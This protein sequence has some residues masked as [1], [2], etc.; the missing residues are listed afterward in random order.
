[1]SQLPSFN[2]L[3]LRAPL[4]SAITELGYETPTPVQ[5]QSIP[6][7]L[8]G[9]DLLA[10]AQTGTGKTAAFAL[11]ILSQI[12]LSVSAPQALI[13]TPTRE[14]AI[15]V[16]EAFQ[17]YARALKGFHVIPIY[18]GQSYTIQLNALK[19]GVQVIVGTPG[20]V[21]DHLRR[22]TIPVNAIKTVVLDEADEMLT[23]GFIEDITWILEQ[24]PHAHQTALFSATMPAAIQQVAKKY[25]ND[26]C[27]V[28]IKPNKQNVAAIEQC[29]IRISANQKL[30]LLTRLLEVETIQAAIVFARTK[31]GSSE[32]AEKLKARGYAATALNGD[33]NQAWREKVIDQLKRGAVDIVVAT[34]VAARGI[35]VERISHVFNFD[36]P[37]DVESYI[38]RIGR[39]G[40]AGRSGKAVLFVTPREY[41]LLNAIERGVQSPIEEIFPPTLKE[42]AEKRGEQLVA[43]V[44]GVLNT[45]DARN[46]TSAINAKGDSTNV[47]HANVHASAEARIFAVRPYLHY[48][49]MI[50]AKTGHDAKAI[51]AALAYL[52]QQDNPMPIDEL[53]RPARDYGRASRGASSKERRSYG[54]NP[55]GK[56]PIKSSKPHKS[57]KSGSSGKSNK[58]SSGNS[59]LSK[60]NY[61]FSKEG[62]TNEKSRMN[63]KSRINE[64]NGPNEKSKSKGKRSKKI[65]QNA[66]QTKPAKPAKLEK[67]TRSTKSAKPKKTVGSSSS[68]SLPD[69]GSPSSLRGG[70]AQRRSTKQSTL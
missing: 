11:P 43:Q 57:K 53:E 16:A 48:I 32:L 60:S 5:A 29:Y 27:H 61:S 3:N 51:A 10:Q 58:L 36:I 31:N 4:L 64:K 62:R 34:D 26:A 8:E 66:G 44:M 39:T 38:H 47:P 50:M 41:R 21:M 17:R 6:V 69:S 20:R 13:I 40:R 65:I 46:A 67:P 19:R 70:Q 55:Y 14:L 68:S 28:Q 37:Y 25:L 22:G 2:A 9:R 45:G 24:I 42:M 35:D 63:E 59:G 7:L 1:M 30:E 33:M 18:G 49:D 12:D 52:I 56:R 15:Q 54:S 23:M